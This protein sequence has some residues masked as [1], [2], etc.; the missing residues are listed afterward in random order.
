M[1]HQQYGSIF[2]L[3]ARMLYRMLILA[4]LGLTAFYLL[5]PSI[6]LYMIDGQALRYTLAPFFSTAF[7]RPGFFYWLADILLN[8]HVLALPGMMI[9]AF[10]RTYGVGKATLAMMVYLLGIS[11]AVFGL[12]SFLNI[13]P[14][15]WLSWLW[16]LES[17]IGPTWTAGHLM[18]AVLLPFSLLYALLLARTALPWIANQDRILWQKLRAL[19]RARLGLAHA[20]AAS[21]P[22]Y[23]LLTL[24]CLFIIVVSWIWQ[25]GTVVWGSY[26]L[27]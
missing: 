19:F 15:S 25:F 20:D 6:P 27:R 12:S 13:L 5:P 10:R 23:G 11:W 1:A 18:V 24:L 4:L 2:F 21:P 22:R 8:N 14:G 7:L 9:F 26:F 16:R 3:F 17:R